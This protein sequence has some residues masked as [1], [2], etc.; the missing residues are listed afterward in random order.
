MKQELDWDVISDD[1]ASAISQWFEQISIRDADVIAGRTT[2]QAGIYDFVRIEYKQG[3]I[4]VF[5][6]DFDFSIAEVEYRGVPQPNRLTDAQLVEELQPRIDRRLR[7]LIEA[8]QQTALLDFAFTVHGTFWTS[9]GISRMVLLRVVSPLKKQQL[10]GNIEAYIQSKLMEPPSAIP[11]DELETFFLARHLVN[12]E[13]YPDLTA[14]DFIQIYER[15]VEMNK[16]NRESVLQHRH[17]IISALRS[18]VENGLL[19][20][21]YDI[22]AKEWHRKE[23]K[24]RESQTAPEP[25]EQ[26]LELLL[27]TAILILKYEP[28]YSRSTGLGYLDRAKELGSDRAARIV[29]EGSGDWKPEEIGYKDEHVT[30][31]AH[32]VFAT[33]TVKIL[34]ESAESYAKALDF[35]IRLLSSGFPKSYL[36]QCQ[37]AT[38]HYLPIKGL[39]RSQTHS[40]FANA[41]Q[42][43]DLHPKLEAYARLAMAEFEWYGDTEGEKNG[44]PGTYAVFGLGLADPEYFPLVREYM[45]LL[46]REHQSVQDRF[47]LAW[48]QKY[49]VNPDTIPTLTACLLGCTDS[50]KLKERTAWKSADNLQALAASLQ[51]CEG[52]E[53][54]HVIDII[55]GGA[56][57]LQALAGKE[58]K[59][60]LKAPLSALA[61]LAA[62]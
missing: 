14:K 62:R 7:P 8:R 44:M 55:W 17:H 3:S 50:V 28:N 36:I 22:H 58:K 47:T 30:C 13:L 12:P 21:Y 45:A 32:D 4:E 52:Y 1:I 39:A 6:S 51:T 60:K 61:E 56:D 2:L 34:R 16:R 9:E 41:L 54:A 59:G 48:A 42:Y 10:L 53:A 11:T 29:K 35:I 26:A 20:L 25:D 15:I 5:S 40:F 18:W 31:K 49:G 23:Y 57:K 43:P 38:K 27:F 33:I 24:L 19:P 46:D 37:S